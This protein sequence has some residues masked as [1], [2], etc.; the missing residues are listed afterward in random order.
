M[1]VQDEFV[2][3]VRWHVENPMLPNNNLIQNLNHTIRLTKTEKPC[4]M[5]R[6]EEKKNSRKSTE[7]SQWASIKESLKY[8]VF[9]KM[10][11]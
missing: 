2:T 5:C 6:E 7:A 10:T 9:D 1:C 4:K 11:Y 8:L 3:C